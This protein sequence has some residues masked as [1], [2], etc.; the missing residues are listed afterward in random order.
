MLSINNTSLLCHIDVMKLGNN[1]LSLTFDQNLA[2]V[3]L[4]NWPKFCALPAY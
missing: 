2:K 1:G 4:N 3:S